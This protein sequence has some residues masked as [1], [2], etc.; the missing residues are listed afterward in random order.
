MS[1]KPALR[2]NE[3]YFSADKNDLLN[4]LA[5]NG[6]VAACVLNPGE[7]DLLLHRMQLQNLIRVGQD[8]KEADRI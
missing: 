7:D 4:F 6:K 2:E 3:A 5:L 1:C 8:L